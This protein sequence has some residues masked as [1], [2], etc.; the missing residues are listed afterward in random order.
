MTIKRILTL[1]NT[2]NLKVKHIT[3]EFEK[4]LINANISAFPGFKLIG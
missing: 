2:K 4:G 3:I 1:E